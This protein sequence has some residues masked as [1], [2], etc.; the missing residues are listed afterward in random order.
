MIEDDFAAGRPA[1]EAAGAELVRDVPPYQEL[2]LRLLNGAHSAIA[3][4]GALLGMTFVA[5]VMADPALARF[6][7]RLMLEEIAPL[8]PRAARLTT[9]RATS[10]PSCAGSRTG[11]CSTARCRSPWTAR[12]RS[13]C[14]GCR[15]CARHGGAACRCPHLVTALAVWLRFLDGRDE[16]GRELP[17]DDPLAPRLRASAARGRRAGSRGAGGCCGIEEVFGRDLREDAG[18]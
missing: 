4:I 14:A 3:Y 13:R 11:R 17:L 9:S 12:R 16:A 10:R 18:P 2:K 15:S 1:W 8:T 5:D 6:V 7:E